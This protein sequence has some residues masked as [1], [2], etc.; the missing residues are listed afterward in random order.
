M[1]KILIPQEI[2]QIGL[3]YLTDKGYELIFCDKDEDSIIKHIKD[4][5]AVTS[6]T[7]LY[8]KKIIDSASKLKIIANSGVGIDNIDVDYATQK[9]IWV[10]NTPGANT[11]SVAEH[12]IYLMLCAAKNAYHTVTEV[13]KGN[14]MIKD[15]LLGKE[16]S[17]GTLGILGAGNIGRAVAKICNLAFNMK[18]IAYDPY[19]SKK[20]I[21]DYIHIVDNIDEIFKKSDIISMHMPYIKDTPPVVGAYEFNLMKP[22]SIFVNT[23]RG[24]TVDELALYKI[25]KENKIFGA[26]IDVTNQEP[27]NIDNKLLSLNNI[28]ITPHHAGL[29]KDSR[30][31]MAL[32]LAKNIHAVLS[33]KAPINPINKL[34]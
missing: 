28:Y 25:L 4:C 17:G 8:T 6:R 32:Q 16:I 7:S 11:V 33:G 5:S 13:R 34:K 2:A 14:W 9:K 26:A 23:S 30:D 1:K 12:T 24:E 3:D 18:I 21:P 29:T 15:K 27:I 22:S 10:T 20:L 19:V 31:T